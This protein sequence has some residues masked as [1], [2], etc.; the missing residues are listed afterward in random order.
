MGYYAT[1]SGV[2]N[3]TEDRLREALQEFRSVMLSPE[4]VEKHAQGGT[5]AD[6]KKLASWYSWCDMKQ[7]SD[8]KSIEDVLE[9]F[10]FEVNVVQDHDRLSLL[11][12][13]SSKVGQEDLLLKTISRFFDPDSY[14]E[15][16]GEDGSH[17][18]YQLGPEFSVRE[19]K[20]VYD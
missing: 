19:G 17:W 5:W 13:Y 12:Y 7:L 9:H 6:G 18:K 20:V 2:L 4:F 3:S 11:V 1:G 10:G 14:V 15:W 8:A 16:Q